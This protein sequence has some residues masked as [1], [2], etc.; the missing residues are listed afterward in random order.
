[1]TATP[2]RPGARS[3]GSLLT[4]RATREELAAIRA[5]ATAKGI[6]AADLTRQALIAM[7]VPITR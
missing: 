3:A 4:V 2:T 6:T 5:T 7:G 1:M